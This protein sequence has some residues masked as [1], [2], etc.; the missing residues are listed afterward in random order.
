MKRR[1]L[2]IERYLHFNNMSAVRFISTKLFI[3]FR[4][5]ILV[6]FADLIINTTLYV[7]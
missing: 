1:R 4:Y 3:N 6:Y 5:I 2:S 7:W